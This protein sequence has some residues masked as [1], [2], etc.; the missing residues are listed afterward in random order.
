MYIFSFPFRYCSPIKH[1]SIRSST[2]IDWYDLVTLV[3]YIGDETKAGSYSH[4][5][6]KNTEK[7]LY[8]LVLQLCVSLK[9]LVPL[10]QQAR[11][12]KKK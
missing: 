4:G 2:T 8:E 11:C 10:A 5:N 9:D 7:N 3:H 1:F 12:T 6:S